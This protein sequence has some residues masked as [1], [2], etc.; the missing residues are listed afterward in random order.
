MANNQWYM[1]QLKKPVDLGG[2]GSTSALKY[3]LAR[4]QIQGGTRTAMEQA[5]ESMGGRGFRAGESGL[6]DTTIAQI[7][8]QGASRLGEAYNQIAI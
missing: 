6:A 1:Q 8:T 7:A 3:G 2:T 5:R 4:G